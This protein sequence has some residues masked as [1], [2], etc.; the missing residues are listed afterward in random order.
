MNVFEIFFVNRK[1]TLYLQIVFEKYEKIRVSATLNLVFFVRYRLL[2][3]R[4]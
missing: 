4:K 2:D 1:K 3:C